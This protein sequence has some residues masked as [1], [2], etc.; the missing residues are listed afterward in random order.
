MRT[1]NQYTAQ[2]P[3]Y[4]AEPDSSVLNGFA[5]GWLKVTSS[6]GVPGYLQDILSIVDANNVLKGALLLFQDILHIGEGE[7]IIAVDNMSSH[8][9]AAGVLEVG[10]GDQ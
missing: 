10:V 8:R 1:P 5:P 7:E 4:L 3:S 2:Y 6:N 9:L